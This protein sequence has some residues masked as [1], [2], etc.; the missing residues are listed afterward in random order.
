MYSNQLAMSDLVGALLRST[1]SP[2]ATE[3]QEGRPYF[4]DDK[5]NDVISSQTA[6][7][8]L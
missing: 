2:L 1:V 3:K 8:K 4:E 7:Y 5:E 6:E